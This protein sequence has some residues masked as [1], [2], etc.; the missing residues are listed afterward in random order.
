MQFR[1]FGW[2]VL[3]VALALVAA[4]CDSPRTAAQDE[5]EELAREEQ[6]RAERAEEQQKQ[7]DMDVAEPVEIVTA[8][9]TRTEDAGS[10]AFELTGTSTAAFF[11]AEFS[12][13]GAFDHTTGD[14]E[15]TITT[16][17]PGME[18]SLEER[19]VDGVVYVNLSDIPGFGGGWISLDVS[20][21]FG[22]DGLGN[23]V[24]AQPSPTE[25][26]DQ[27]RAAGDVEEV[28]TE[29]VRG[30]EVVHYTAN[31][32]F[33]KLLDE[34]VD[35]LGETLGADQVDFFTQLLD[36][37]GG[38]ATVDVWINDDGLPVRYTTTS[39]LDIDGQTVEGNITIDF[40]DFGIDVSPEAPP[41][42]EVMS[43]DDVLGGLGGLGG[44]IAD[45][46]QG[47]QG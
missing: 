10:S 19:V 11:T 22:T 8:A 39:S 37:V 18:L 20:E 23:S 29:E 12:A 35:A 40:F 5:S 42:D 36:E 26:L 1:R 9:I 34:G 45:V 14:G 7:L 33:R 46:P 15:M 25:Q 28:G 30:E 31:L 44:D 38:D 47:V 41:A 21:A 24:G 27:L 2:L 43:F 13:N 3:V 32:D 6:E 4:A 17:A 16:E